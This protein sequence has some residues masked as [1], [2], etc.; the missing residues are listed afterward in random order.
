MAQI[1][2]FVF[3]EVKLH[4]QALLCV[5]SGPT[6]TNNF[7]PLT[8]T[9]HTSQ[10]W[11][12]TLVLIHHSCCRASQIIIMTVLISYSYISTLANNCGLKTPTIQLKYEHMNTKMGV[13]TQALFANK[14]HGFKQF[15]LLQQVLCVLFV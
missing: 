14:F 13:L 15:S 11:L 5:E 8:S 12:I 6:L 7:G 3:L 1:L 9:I 10:L 2:V 4:P